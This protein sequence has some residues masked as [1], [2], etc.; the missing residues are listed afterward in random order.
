MGMR[1]LGVIVLLGAALLPFSA[2][3]GRVP[4]DGREATSLLGAAL[5]A[6]PLDE[7][8]RAKLEE[9]LAE[10]LRNAEREAS[11]ENMIWVGRRLAYLGRYR[12]AVSA[13]GRGLERYPRSHR[14]LRHRGHR[15]ITL[16]EFDRAIDDLFLAWKLAEHEE[17]RVEPD[18]APTPGVPPR[19]TDKSNILYHLGL[20]HFLKGDFENALDAF[21][22]RRTLPGLNDDTIVSSMHWEYMCLRRL[23]RPE[24]AAELVSGVSE[25]MDVRENQ[26]YHALVLLYAGK[27]KPERAA[28]AAPDSGPASF[29]VRYGL[30]A[31]KLY[32]EGDLEGARREFE[33]IVGDDPA[34]N[35]PAFGFIAA[36]AELARMR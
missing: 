8:R 29:A 2:G 15:F 33:A 6:P 26:S 19:S 1:S 27:L 17:D 25:K 28:R 32:H 21:D 24:A 14:L 3:Q 10:A 11:E 13:F 12:E 16:R 9:D 4:D 5:H 18:G 20:A 30:A 7:A 34:A 22:L 35:W 31:W 36:E 23:G